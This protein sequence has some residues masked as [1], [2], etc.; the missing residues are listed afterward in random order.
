M[1]VTYDQHGKSRGI[2]QVIFSKADSAPKAAKVNGS[3]VDGHPMK[4]SQSGVP[5]TIC[6]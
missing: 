6:T 4:V 3:L 5:F 1:V 2:A